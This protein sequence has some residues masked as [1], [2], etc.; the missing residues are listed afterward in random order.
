MVSLWLTVSVSVAGGI[1]LNP[2]FLGCIRGP[3]ILNQGYLSKRNIKT[4]TEMWRHA[5]R[6]YQK[7]L[8][9]INNS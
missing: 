7:I 2:V 8:K 4:K 1:T 9:L 6:S 5:Y 3:G